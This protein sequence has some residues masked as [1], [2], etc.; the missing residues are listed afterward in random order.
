MRA[1]PLQAMLDPL[2]L[3]WM[4]PELKQLIDDLLA[5]GASKQQ[6]LRSC[7]AAVARIR[8]TPA[9]GIPTLTAVEAYLRTKE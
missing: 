7:A 3:E 4:Q 5:K 8:R 9:E 2:L 6:I 1:N